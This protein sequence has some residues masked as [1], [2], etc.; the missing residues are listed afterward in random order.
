VCGKAI[1]REAKGGRR[2]RRKW[3]LGKEETCGKRKRKFGKAEIGKLR[4]W[5][6]A[7]GRIAML[8]RGR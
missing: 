7:E 4:N 3:K 6:K 8:S 5:G 2:K 1:R